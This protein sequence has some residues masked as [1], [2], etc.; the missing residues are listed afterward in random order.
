MDDSGRKAH[1]SDAPYTWLA[2]G[3][4]EVRASEKH[5]P[6]VSALAVFG[7]NTAKDSVDFV[8]EMVEHDGRALV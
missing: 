1:I 3:V 2:H 7:G 5:D 4:D 8:I 6:A